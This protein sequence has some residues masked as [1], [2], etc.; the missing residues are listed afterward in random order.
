MTDFA[1]FSDKKYSRERLIAAILFI[2]QVVAGTGCCLSATSIDTF[3][4]WFA[5]ANGAKMRNWEAPSNGMLPW[6]ARQQ[7]IWSIQD[8]RFY[9]CNPKAT[10]DR[11]MQNAFWV[12]L[13]FMRDT[14]LQTIGT[15]PSPSYISYSQ[16]RYLY[17][18]VPIR[19]DG[20]VETM[21]IL[22]YEKMLQKADSTH[23][24][25]ES[26]PE[27]RYIFVAEKNQQFSSYIETIGRETLCVDI[28]YD[29]NSFAENA[30][31]RNILRYHKAQSM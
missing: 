15:G 1:L 11:Q 26:L 31:V 27:E 4:L 17:H 23:K 29:S 21:R 20:V 2:I 6:L 7:R 10:P 8:G 30:T 14:Q 25:G 16:N 9:A 12:L 28:E 5:K 18:I 22:Q 24:I 3:A 19:S 13:Q